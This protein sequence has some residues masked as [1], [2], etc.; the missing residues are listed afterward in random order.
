MVHPECKAEVTELAD[1][2]G[3]TTGIMNF[4]AQSDAKEFI[5][6][7]DTTIAEHLR[8]AHPEKRFYPL[9]KKCVCHDMRLTTLMEVYQ[10]LNGAAGEE[11]VLTD[12]VRLN[13]QKSI[14][15]ML[16]K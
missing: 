16:G 10:C 15:R 4:A 8:F 3:S 1:Y 2:A 11:I 5:I 14:D 12:E 13:A 7:T 6:G 9:S